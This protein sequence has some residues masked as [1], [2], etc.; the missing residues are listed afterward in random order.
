LVLPRLD[1][2]Q[3]AQALQDL[4]VA[5]VMVAPDSKW[6]GKPLGELELRARYHVSVLAARHRGEPHTT[7]LASQRLDFGDTLLV[8]GDWNDLTRMWEDRQH[9]VA[10]T[11][12]AEYRERLPARQRLPIAVGILVGMIAVM[13]FELMP[14][15]AAALFAAMAMLATRC[16]GVDAIYRVISWKTVVL[17]AG[18]LPLATALTKTGAT[19]L[20]AHGLVSTLGTLGPIAMLVVVFLVTAVVGLFI[21]NAATAVL[22]APVALEAAQKLHVSPRALAMTVT[23]GCCAA[24]VTPVSSPVNM[25]VMEPGGY[26]FG[27]YVKIG[28][29]LL[30]LTMVVTIALVAV[31]YPL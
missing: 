8:A 1:E 27:D 28:L 25:L 24:F 11:L 30:L 14:N 12:P 10:L 22:V 23:I 9:F 7:H 31:I 16:I 5:E 6:I 19:E 17:T 26:T 3:R 21:S 29:P 13:A 15:A 18:L 20:M 2:R 4:G